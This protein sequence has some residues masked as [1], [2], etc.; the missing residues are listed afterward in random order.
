LSRADLV[1]RARVYDAGR[2]AEDEGRV[3]GVKETQRALVA[4]H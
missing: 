2:D 1:R 3:A 4:G